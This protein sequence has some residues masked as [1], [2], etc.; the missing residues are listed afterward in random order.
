MLCFQDFRPAETRSALLFCLFRRPLFAAGRDALTTASPITGEERRGVIT[1]ERGPMC[2]NNVLNISGNEVA[3]CP[4]K[5]GWEKGWKCSIEVIGGDF[6][7]T[8]YCF[9]NFFVFGEGKVF[10][11]SRSTC[12]H[13][14]LM[15][16]TTKMPYYYI[17]FF[18]AEI[19]QYRPGQK[20][21]QFSKN[22]MFFAQ[23][24]K[25]FKIIS[26]KN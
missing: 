6:T 18:F 2:A 23:V 26:V 4:S 1:P 12:F 16:E 19:V 5:G 22:L 25:F 20:P 3:K 13:A 14:T 21:L 9:H 8:F 24:H 11:S 7:E 15:Y 17:Y 10:Q